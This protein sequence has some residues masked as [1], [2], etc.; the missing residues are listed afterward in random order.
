MRSGPVSPVR[1]RGGG[2]SCRGVPIGEEEMGKLGGTGDPR[3]EEEER[4]EVLQCS[5]E[6]DGGWGVVEENVGVG[7]RERE[8]ESEMVS[9]LVVVTG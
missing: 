5:E 4:G 1:V 6:V 2:E 7:E 8:K 9:V 3:E